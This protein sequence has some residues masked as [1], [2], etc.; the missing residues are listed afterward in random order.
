MASRHATTSTGGD[1]CRITNRWAAHSRALTLKA[2][3]TPVPCNNKVTCIQKLSTSLS[4]LNADNSDVRRRWTLHRTWADFQAGADAMANALV[5][6]SIDGCK[7][8]QSMRWTS[9][10]SSRTTGSS[11]TPLSSRRTWATTGAVCDSMARKRERNAPRKINSFLPTSAGNG[12][13]PLSPTGRTEPSGFSATNIENRTRTAM[14]F[15]MI[16]S[17][18]FSSKSSESTS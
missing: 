1:P 5:A 15:A 16:T 10:K 4:T 11:H 13:P 9:R 8:V 3:K 2:S 12:A 17:T 7:S 6:A 14:T 18:A